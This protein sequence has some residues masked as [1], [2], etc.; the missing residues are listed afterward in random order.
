MR[1]EK[2]IIFCDDSLHSDLFVRL[3]G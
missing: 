3:L 1:N 2:I